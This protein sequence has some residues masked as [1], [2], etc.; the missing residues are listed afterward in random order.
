[1]KAPAPSRRGR[2]PTILADLKMPGALEAVDGILAD[3]D[4]GTITAAEAIERSSGLSSRAAHRLLLDTPGGASLPHGR[5]LC[6]QESDRRM[7]RAARGL[8]RDHHKVARQGLTLRVERGEA[9]STVR[10]I[11]RYHRTVVGGADRRHRLDAGRPH[12]GHPQTGY[13]AGKDH[14]LTAGGGGRSTPMPGSAGCACTNCGT[15]PPVRPSWLARICPWSAK[16]SPTGGTGPQ[17]AMPTLRTG[18]LSRRLNRL[19]RSLQRLWNTPN[20]VVAAVALQSQTEKHERF[21]L[22]FLI[23]T[24][25][26]YYLPMIGV[27]VA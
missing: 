18:I 2:L 6:H 24:I 4:S 5:L 13:P 12:R 10:E 1:M 20:H 27:M 19:A 25:N 22:F 3:A 8:A 9:A 11:G 17:R 23:I 16:F 26:T 21:I 14:R 15:P 7:C